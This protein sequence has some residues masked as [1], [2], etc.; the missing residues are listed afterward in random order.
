[1]KKKP[2]ADQSV[3]LIDLPPLSERLQYMTGLRLAFAFVVFVLHFWGSRFTGLTPVEVLPATV[4]FLTATLVNEFA[5]RLLHRRGLPLLATMLVMDGIYLAWVA[6]ATGGPTSPLRF[7]IYLHLI[8]VTLL[9][10][11]RTGLK[12][13]LW[14]S[15]MFF[16]AFYA[17]LAGWV[18]PFVPIRGSVEAAAAEFNR[19]SVLNILAFWFVAIGTALF[20][21]SN[22]K[23]L[24]R[25]RDDVGRLAEMAVELEKENEP[26]SVARV[27]LRRL[28]ANFHVERAVFVAGRDSLRILAY[29]G[30]VPWHQVTPNADAL[31]VE[32]WSDRRTRLVRQPDPSSNPM[33]ASLFPAGKGLIVVPLYAE[34]RSVGVIVLERGDP[35]AAIERREIVLMEQFATYA[36]LALRNAWALEEIRKLAQIDPL[37][38]LANRGTFQESLTRELSRA[39]R[40]GEPVTLLIL[41]IDH[42]KQVNDTYGHQIG[43]DVIKNIASTLASV[44]RDF[45]TAARYGGEEFAV[46]L[47]GC[48]AQDSRAIAERFRTKIKAH[49]EPLEVTSSVGVAT[50][51]TDAGNSKDLIKLADDALYESKRAGRDRVT[52]ATDAL[53]SASVGQ[54]RE[55]PSEATPPLDL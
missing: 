4:I 17:Q 46:I 40:S 44:K 34:A 48:N 23:E 1:M 37:T 30:E 25:N 14:H 6:F 11:Y 24:R 20:S 12:V 33:L 26:R 42:F 53:T 29:D 19:L 16:V 18:E 28:A 41:D 9:A 43:D 32:A 3:S 22:E 39:D 50:Y 8:G 21:A 2:L 5:R 45:D 49:R 52:L 47:P 35:M 31:I 36:A 13:A 51:P 54:M 15:L 7:L 55:A 27:T 10:S 38:G